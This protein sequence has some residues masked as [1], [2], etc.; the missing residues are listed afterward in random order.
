MLLNLVEN[1]FSH[2][3]LEFCSM[4]EMISSFRKPVLEEEAE[5]EG[6]ISSG[7]DKISTSLLVR[8]G[9]GITYL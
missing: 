5:E 9:R 8:E 6:L 2:L 1:P 7:K 3:L 4:L